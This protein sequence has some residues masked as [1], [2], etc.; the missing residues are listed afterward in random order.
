MFHFTGRKIKERLKCLIVET[1]DESFFH[2]STLCNCNYYKNKNCK[3]FRFYKMSHCN[4]Y[5]VSVYH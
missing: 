3:D 1:F 2:S 4:I 5:L